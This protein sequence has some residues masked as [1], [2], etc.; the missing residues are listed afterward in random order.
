MEPDGRFANHSNRWSVWQD[1]R[2]SVFT[3]QQRE[4][5]EKLHVQGVEVRVDPA[6]IVK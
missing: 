1:G 4:E 5:E 6:V 2:R 3:G